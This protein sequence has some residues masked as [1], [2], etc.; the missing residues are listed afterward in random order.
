VL[1]ASVPGWSNARECDKYPE[2]TS[3]EIPLA[4]GNRY[5]IEALHKEGGGGD[6]LAV[7]WTIPGNEFNV[8]DGLFLS[9]MENKPPVYTVT[10]QAESN[11]MIFGE[12]IQTI[13][14]GE[15]CQPVTAVPD[16]GYRFTSWTGDYDGTEATITLTNISKNMTITAH[17][18]KK[19]YTVNF[20]AGSGGSINGITT[21]A[22][23]H[24]DNC[25][26]VIAIPDSNARFTGW[27]GDFTYAGEDL[28]IQNV[29]S[30]MTITA[31]FTLKT[32]TVTFLAGNG[33]TLS[34]ETRQTITHGEASSEVTAI[35][36]T[37]QHFTGWTGDFSGTLTQ[38][39]VP[40][41]ISDMT[42]T[43]EFSV[44]IYAVN[45]SASTG[46]AI[47]GE[48]I[49]SVPH[50]EQFSPIMA[51]PNEGYHFTGWSGSISGDSPI[52]NPAEVTENITATALFEINT[53]HLLFAAGENG[54]LEGF[55]SQ[56]LTHGESSQ[57]ITA[58]PDEHYD[59]KGW[60]GDF[61]GTSETLTLEN[62]T[63]DMTID[64]VFIKQKGIANE[65]QEE[66]ACFISNLQ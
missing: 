24:G 22:V 5:Y 61:S 26:T 33:G 9:P 56:T 3:I 41:V 20:I 27:Q 12:S 48:S 39:S 62:I 45:F 17:F 52:L 43:A 30:D 57:A 7:G 59:F 42:L 32:Y 64:A 23:T 58:V 50:G 51:I 37:G 40:E 16:S 10:F 36:D 31:N 4:H 15:N 53:Y 60:E 8:I 63:S 13:S 14:E 44:N 54:H 65:A 66:T 55:S 21:Q 11:G 18:S 34:G 6:H 2:Q 38:L 29:I 19:V 25:S 47:Q 46:G 35:A 49:Q 28:S 1:I